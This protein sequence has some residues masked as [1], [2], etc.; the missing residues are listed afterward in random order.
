[1]V[2]AAAAGGWSE[3]VDA[4]WQLVACSALGG[5]VYAGLVW[6]LARRDLREVIGFVRSRKAP[7]AGLRQDV[8]NRPSPQAAPS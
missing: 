3:P 8:T 6:L 5:A 1:V 4:F 7:S 2:A